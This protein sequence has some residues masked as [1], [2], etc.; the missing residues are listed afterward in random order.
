MTVTN[1]VVI[2][3]VPSLFEQE[4]PYVYSLGVFILFTVSRPV[5]HVCPFCV[6]VAL[7]A[8]PSVQFVSSPLAIQVLAPIGFH[9]MILVL[10]Y[11]LEQLE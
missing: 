7:G 1:V 11:L 6:C 4:I 3:V 9:I 8:E 2:S 5:V 10:E